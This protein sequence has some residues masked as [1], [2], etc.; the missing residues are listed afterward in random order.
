[1]L[2]HYSKKDNQNEEILELAE[3]Y[4][5]SLNGLDKNGDIFRYPCS[6]SNEYKFNDEEIDVA[7]FYEY[8]LGLFHFI[9]SCDAWLDNIKEYEMEMRKEY[10]ADMRSEWE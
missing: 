6:Y 8:L 9:D 2:V 5:R 7:N 10:E 4:I 3:S 1:M